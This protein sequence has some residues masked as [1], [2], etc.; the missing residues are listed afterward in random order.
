MKICNKCNTECSDDM[1][2]CT[3]CGEKFETEAVKTEKAAENV[4]TV[5]SS[6]TM[7]FMEATKVFFKKYVDFNGRASRAE[8]WWS[9]LACAIIGFVAGFTLILAPIAVLGLF[10]PSYAAMVRRLHDT[11]KSG[12]WAA[13]GFI[14]LGIVPLIMCILEGEPGANK[15]GEKPAK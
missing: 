2:F 11:G 13:L 7:G 8:Y 4:N 1:L 5:T 3:E 9:Y 15:Y 14:G 12:W 6:E 10:I